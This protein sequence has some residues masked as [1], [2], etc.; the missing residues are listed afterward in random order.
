MT[1]FEFLNAMTAHESAE[2]DQQV[3]Y[4]VYLWQKNDN[5]YGFVEHLWFV[6]EMNFKKSYSLLSGTLTENTVYLKGKLGESVVLEGEI[7]P[8]K[9]LQNIDIIFSG[10]PGRNSKSIS[11][12]TC[13]QDMVE[14]FKS[15]NSKEQIELYY[16]KE[17][18]Q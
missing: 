6:T 4:T 2:Y 14:S 12:Q 17:I 15:L 1:K 16:H 9:T 13:C 18:E 3:T 11:F 8:K 5:L 10:N 7:T